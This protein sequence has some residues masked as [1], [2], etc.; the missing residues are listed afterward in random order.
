LFILLRLEVT[1]MTTTH[2]KDLDG[3]RIR[4]S[5]WRKR[6][7]VRKREAEK[8]FDKIWSIKEQTAKDAVKGFTYSNGM[9]APKAAKEE[10]ENGVAAAATK[11]VVPI[12]PFCDKKGHKTMNAKH[13]KFSTKKESKHSKVDNEERG[14]GKLYVEFV[15][16]V[17]SKYSTVKKRT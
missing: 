14:T 6:P 4:K 12:C 9:A 16:C 8:A 15:L 1:L 5:V 10:S 13:C 3:H 17:L 11:K 2:H 7:E